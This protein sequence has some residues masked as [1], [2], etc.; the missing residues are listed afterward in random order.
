MNMKLPSAIGLHAEFYHK[1]RKYVNQNKR[2]LAD[3]DQKKKKTTNEVATSLRVR[4]SHFRCV[5]YRFVGR[6]AVHPRRPSY[7]TARE[8]EW[9]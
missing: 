9:W 1:C 8:I 5:P 6:T 2:I 3:L 7:V 4:V